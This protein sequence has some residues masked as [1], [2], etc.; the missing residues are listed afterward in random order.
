MSR[1]C[2]ASVLAFVERHPDFVE[3]HR[4]TLLP[5]EVFFQSLVM[6]G[7]N[8][9]LHGRVTGENLHAIRWAPAGRSPEALRFE[10]LAELQ[11]SPKLFGRKFDPV[12]EP[13]LLDAIDRWWRE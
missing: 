4:H 2:V 1:E 13:D 11:A 9:H 6:G 10:H 12:V 3:F 7:E 5:D 8:A